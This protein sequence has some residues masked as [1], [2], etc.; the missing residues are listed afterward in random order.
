MRPSVAPR[1]QPACSGGAAAGL[2]RASAEV[3][4]DFAQGVQLGTAEVRGWKAWVLLDVGDN[5]CQRPI[6]FLDQAALE[7][8]HEQSGEALRLIREGQEPA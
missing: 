7:R 6:A 2:E 8:I 5:G 1:R 4:V 3:K